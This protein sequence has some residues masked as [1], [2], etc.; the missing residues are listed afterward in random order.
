MALN[1]ENHN[2]IF[3]LLFFSGVRFLKIIL[4]GGRATSR[5][6]KWKTS[7][8]RTWKFDCTPIV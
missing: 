8:Q 1:G 5:S 3:L 4:D 2:G 6:R 7:S